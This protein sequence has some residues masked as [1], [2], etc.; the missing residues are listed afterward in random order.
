M[1]AEGGT[2]GYIQHHLTNLAV[3][4]D[5]AKVDGV[6][7]GFWTFH[8]DTLLVSGILGLV[9]FGLMASSPVFARNSCH[10]SELPVYSGKPSIFLLQKLTHL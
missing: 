8:L 5:S 9:V 7:T 4:A 1:S 2:T 10:I 6:C 3:C